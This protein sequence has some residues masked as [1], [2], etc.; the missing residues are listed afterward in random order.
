M[1]SGVMR[2]RRAGVSILAA[3]S[4]LGLTGMGG[5]AV[6]LNRGYEM[7]IVNQQVADM[8]ALAAGVAYTGSQSADVLQPTAQD[9][10]V[11]QGLRDAT[12]AATLVSDVPT[13]GAKAVRVTVTTPLRISLARVLGA[14]ASY[15]VAAVATASLP[16]QGTPACIIGLATSGNAIETQGGASINA[17]D[18]A[19]AG[20]GSVSNK[21]Q[22]ITAKALVSGSGSV[23]NDYGTIVADQVR[24]AVDFTNPSWNTNVPAADK[25]VRQATSVTDPLANDATLG[26]ARNLLGTYRTPRAPTNP[27]TPGGGAAWSFS[28]TPSAATADFREG[29]TSNFSVPAG[30]YTIDTLDIAGGIRVTFA[31]GSVVTVARGVTIGG[32]STV[33]FGDGTYRINGGFSSGSSGVTFG[34]GELHIGQG[35]VSFAGTNRIG[36]GNVTIAAPLSLGG[37]ATLAIGAG[38]HLFGGISVGGGS[39]LTLGNGA[40]DVTGAIT[41][42]GD[43]SII[44]GAG[45]VTLANPGGR[46]IDL[47]GS[48]CLFMGDGLFSANGDIVTAGGSRLVFGRTANHLVNGNLQIA[49]SVLFGAGRYTVK[50]GFTN[51]TGGTTWPYSSSITGQRWGDT[52]EGVSV[53]GYDMAGVGVTFILGG[54]VN[55]GGGAKTKL[56]A[57]ASSTTGGGV[58]DILIDSLT[59]VD[60][61]WGA[62]SDN[63]FVGTVHLPNSAVTMSGG[64]STQSGGRCFMLIALRVVVSGGAAAGSVCPG[65]NGSGGGGS[66]SVELIA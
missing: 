17:P 50:G 34:N 45:D 29:Q 55:L 8:A 62:G 60:T 3:L 15:P 53:S 49:G 65:V 24:Y 38:N 12:V 1:V 42:G 11:A 40:L 47:S 7:R 20:V 37:G 58:A 43:S 33:T 10:A 19:V 61:T 21:G 63:L 14:A 39:W 31:P 51:G 52:L 57:P 25:R 13:S 32:G 9:L 26:D 35:N 48:G 41:V 4:V 18:C 5:L 23:I 66:T 30:R 59:S 27:V 54:T 64:N 16:T 28:S 36:D 2:D 44:A 22:A 46:A 6:D 56:L